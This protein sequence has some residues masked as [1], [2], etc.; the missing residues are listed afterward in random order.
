MRFRAPDQRGNTTE[1]A[2]AGDVEAAGFSFDKHE[3]PPGP[4]DWF[5]VLQAF[6]VFGC[7][8]AGSG[9]VSNRVLGGLIGWALALVAIW[10]IRPVIGQIRAK[11]WIPA[12]ETA[13][14]KRYFCPACLYPIDG[15][16]TESDGCTVCP[17]CNAAWRLPNKEYHQ[18]RASHA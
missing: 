11:T 9:V 4:Y 15:L 2:T 7:L 17:E 13:L 16:K 5:D 1:R 6:V 14:L 10:L 8:L 18:Q 3:L 12:F